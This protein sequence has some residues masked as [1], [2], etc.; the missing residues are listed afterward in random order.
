MDADIQDTLGVMVVWRDGV[1]QCVV[2][3]CQVHRLQ[4]VPVVAVTTRGFLMFGDIMHYVE[5]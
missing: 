5:F 2:F 4:A 1:V 3:W